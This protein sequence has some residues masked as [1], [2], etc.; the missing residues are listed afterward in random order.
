MGTRTY[1]G[2]LHWALKPKCCA[3][4]SANRRVYN[5]ILKKDASAK[6]HIDKNT[7]HTGTMKNSSMLGC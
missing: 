2:A 1:V 4:L 6:K 3:T 7:P 5:F